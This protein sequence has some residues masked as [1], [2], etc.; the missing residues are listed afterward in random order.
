MITPWKESYDQPRQHIQKQRHYF[1]NKCSSSQGYGFSCGHVW[2]WVWVNSWSWWWTGSPG[3]LPFMGSQI[4]RHGC[5][6][7]LIWSDL[8]PSWASLLRGYCFWFGNWVGSQDSD[9]QSISVSSSMNPLIPYLGVNFVP[10]KFFCPIG[11]TIMGSSA[12]TK[13]CRALGAKNF[14]S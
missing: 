8:S 11:E 13:S 14:E 6:T 10:S 4:V 1:A 5:E 7:D 2:M 9:N 12:V 3:V